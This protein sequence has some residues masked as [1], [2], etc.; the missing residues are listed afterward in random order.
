M[1]FKCSLIDII[2]FVIETLLNWPDNFIAGYPHD[3]ILSS[4]ALEL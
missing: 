1:Q 4:C 2:M 3:Y